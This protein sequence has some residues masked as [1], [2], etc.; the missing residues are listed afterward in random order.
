MSSPTSARPPRPNNLPDVRLGDPK[1][2]AFLNKATGG[3]EE[4]W[5]APVEPPAFHEVSPPVVQQQ[6]APVAAP[7]PPVSVPAPM[8]APPPPL[9]PS[10]YAPAPQPQRELMRPWTMRLPPDI[11][12]NLKWLSE[13]GGPSMNEFILHALREALPPAIEKLTKAHAMGL[14][15]KRG[16]GG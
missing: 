13:N 11:H 2:E 1:V 4:H 7:P 14:Y 8:P 10:T 16:R 12:A 6:A 9:A 3:G 5:P 15:V